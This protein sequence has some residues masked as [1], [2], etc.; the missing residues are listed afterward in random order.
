M[1]NSNIENTSDLKSKNYPLI[2]VDNDSFRIMKARA[3]AAE[4]KLEALELVIICA[5]DIVKAWPSMAIR[6]IGTM[7]NRVD[8]LKQALEASSN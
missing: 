8:T 6:T 5:N 7:T 1:I 2:I 4:K 3:E